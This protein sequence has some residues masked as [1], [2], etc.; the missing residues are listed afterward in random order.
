M[1]LSQRL[2]WLLLALVGWSLMTGGGGANT[3]T[4]KPTAATYVYE[5]DDTAI[6]SEV[7]VAIDKL[8]RRDDFVASLFEDDTV[9]GEGQVPAQFALALDAAKKAG[10]PALVVQAGDKVVRVV[11]APMTEAAVLEAVP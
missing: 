9:N 8:N 6:P 1:T 4:D 7:K 5:K 11:K 3:T 2:P 10:E